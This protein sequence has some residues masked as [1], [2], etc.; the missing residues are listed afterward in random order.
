[1][2]KSWKIMKTVIGNKR[3][4]IKNKTMF[5][6]NLKNIDSELKIAK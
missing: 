3:K 2:K 5:N 1:M 4:T 6:I